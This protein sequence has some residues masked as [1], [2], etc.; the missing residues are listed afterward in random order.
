LKEPKSS[1]KSISE[2]EII[3]YNAQG[4]KDTCDLVD[5][6]GTML[7]QF[8]QESHRD[9]MPSK[10]SFRGS[11]KIVDVS[12]IMTVF[13]YPEELDFDKE[14]EELRE[15]VLYSVKT[16]LIPSFMKKVIFKGNTGNTYFK[17]RN[18][19]DDIPPYDKQ[20]SAK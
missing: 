13:F 10:K 8:N 3:S 19:G 12:H 5:C 1:K 2:R 20:Y 4:F 7:S 15:Q 17:S 16:R 6:A 11:G 14:P 9:K 18:S